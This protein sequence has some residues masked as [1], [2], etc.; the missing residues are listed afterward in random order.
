MRK[1]PI[2][3]A[4]LLALTVFSG[5]HLQTSSLQ[6]QVR[7]GTNYFTLALAG[8]PDSSLAPLIRQN[9]E[10]W[11]S[12]QSRAVIVYGPQATK[13]ALSIIEKALLAKG[14][15]RNRISLRAMPEE[16]LEVVL[17]TWKLKQDMAEIGPMDDFWLTRKSV[18]PYFAR[19]TNANIA[20][21]V[22]DKIDL[23]TPRSLG[24]PN[25][26]SAVGA[27]QRYQKGEVREIGEQSL[28]PGEAGGE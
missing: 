15:P 25:P 28:Q 11:N 5:C 12:E 26:M 10:Q 24:T 9:L 14:F 21:Q 17:E 6:N 7:P 20:A 2:L 1:I 3:L 4:A 22:V 8:L 27:V 23:F 16:R 13:S 18:H 19:A